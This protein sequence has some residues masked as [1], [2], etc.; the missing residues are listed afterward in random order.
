MSDC[1]DTSCDAPAATDHAYRRVLWI[2]LA[3]NAVMFVVESVAGYFAHSA[4]LQ[5]DAIDFLGDS[6]NFI[7]ALYVLNKT[8]HWKS[9]AALIKGG[10]IG[11]F[12]LF[13]LGNT[14]YHW[15]YGILP[16]AEAMGIIGLLALAVNASCASLLFRFRKGDSNRSSV[17]ICSRNDAI[18]NILVI[19]AGIVV[20]FTGSKLPDLIVSLIIA[21]L[22]LSGALQIIRKACHELHWIKA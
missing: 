12:G 8:L 4:A 6:L 9:S 7:S 2:V 1:C 3:L 16:Q 5:A 21:A 11:L 13:V 10:V 14:F 18:A 22:A 20:Y 15:L 19:S 17:W